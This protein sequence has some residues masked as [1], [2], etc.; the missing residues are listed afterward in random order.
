MLD[1]IL[2]AVD[3]SD[4]SKHALRWAGAQAGRFHSRVTVISVIE[5]L[6]AEAARIRLGRDLAGEDTEA[7]LREFVAATWS[8]ADG[9]QD[10]RSRGFRLESPP[11]P[12]STPQRSKAP[13]LIVMGTQGLSGFRKWLLGSTTERVLR[14][15]PV[16]VLAVPLA[17]GPQAAH[18]NGLEISR[19]L[20]ATDFSECSAAAAKMAADLAVHLSARLILAHVV[21]PLVV[22][23]EWQPLVQ[24]SNER[25]IRSARATLQGQAKQLCGGACDAVVS[26]GHPVDSISSIARDRGAQLIVMGLSSDRGTFASRPG[27]TAYQVLSSGTVPTLVVP[28]DQK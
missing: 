23:E 17:T 5:P 8:P 21:A 12:S 26:V 6:L 9:V 15:T 28:S 19:V 10:K 3:F 27:S 16:P 13:S 22:P 7:A 24:E 14:R 25:R 11:R 2:S 1:L 4:Q 18:E 20:A